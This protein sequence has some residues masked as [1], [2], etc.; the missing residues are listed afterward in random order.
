MLSNS[1]YTQCTLK[2]LEII[3]TM[4]LLY[5]ALSLNGQK[6]FQM[7]TQACHSLH[8][9]MCVGGS[10]KKMQKIFHFEY[11]Q[12]VLFSIWVTYC[13]RLMKWGG[14]NPVYNIFCNIAKQFS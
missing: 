7:F 9:Q 14:N 5:K 10:G 13:G 8:G 3:F 6:A 11:L 2:A 1:Q 4:T 12:E